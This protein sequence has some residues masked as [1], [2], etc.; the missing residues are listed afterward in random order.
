[1][2]SG[3]KG[4]MDPN[5]FEN[6]ART[7]GGHGYNYGYEYTGDLDPSQYLRNL[8]AE[9]AY[10]TGSRWAPYWEQ[11]FQMGVEARQQEENLRRM[12]EAL[13][14]GSSAAAAAA[15]AQQAALAAQ[16][17]EQERMAGEAKRDSMYSS[18]MD[19]VSLATDYVNAQ[20]ADEIARANLMGVKYD[21]TDEGKQNRLQDYFASIWGEGEQQELQALI[22]QWGAPSG[23]DGWVLERGEAK[24]IEDPGAQK[25]VG[26]RTKK[27]APPPREEETQIAP[28]ATLATSDALGQK[29]L[30]G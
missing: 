29:M 23:F 15:R 18:Y 13:A 8:G 20:I 10:D 21:I 6:N 16:L 11:G 14:G 22:D 28:A 26:T 7:A 3:G 9:G 1:M 19:A 5:E 27:V 12:Q 30:L 2:G 25:K 4:G 17:A 24:I